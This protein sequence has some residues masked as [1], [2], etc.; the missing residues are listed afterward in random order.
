[1]ETQQQQD[2]A[3]AAGLTGYV[4]VNDWFDRYAGKVFE[5]HSAVDWFIK[6]HR[7]ELIEEGALITRAGRSGSLISIEVFPQVVIKILK[8]RA[9]EKS[10]PQA[11]GA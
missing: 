4:G 9:L 8:R 1:M 11:P 3:A 5:T 6:Q 2:H 7:R 10:A